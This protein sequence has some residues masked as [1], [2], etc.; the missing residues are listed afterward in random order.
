ME[1]ALFS[2]KLTRLERD[3]D[4]EMSSFVFEFRSN[5]QSEGGLLTYEV[6]VRVFFHHFCMSRSLRLSVLI[7]RFN[8]LHKNKTLSDSPGR[9]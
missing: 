8:F 2:F 9:Q 6:L 5:S 4:S 7:T 1:K 3:S